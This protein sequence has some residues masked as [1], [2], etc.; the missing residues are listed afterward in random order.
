ME[1]F[2][3]WTASPPEPEI[4]GSINEMQIAEII[5]EED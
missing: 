1:L 4:H 2:I 3:V 5:D